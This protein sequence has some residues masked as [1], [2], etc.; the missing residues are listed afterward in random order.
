MSKTM[1][2]T[3]KTYKNSQPVEPAGAPPP[4]RTNSLCRILVVDKNSDLRLLYADALAGPRCRVDVAEDGEAAWEALQADRYNLLITENKLPNLVGNELLRKLRAAGMDLPVVIVAGS[5]PLHEAAPNLSLPCAATLLKPF[6]LDALLD[7]VKN[8]LCA[9]VPMGML[10]FCLP[11]AIHGLEAER[12]RALLLPSPNRAAR[13]IAVTL[14][15]HGKC[16]YSQDDV[17]FAKLERGRVLKQGAIVR[18][19]QDA[20]TDLLL[21]R[22]GTSVRLLAGTEIKLEKMDLAIK[23]GL[24]VVHT[25]LALHTGRLLTVV[26][27]T[28]AGSTLEIRN[29]AGRAAAEASGLSRCIIT[30]DGTHVWAQ[31]SA[32]PIKVKGENGRTIIAAGQH[33][34]RKEGPF[35]PASTNSWVKDLI[36]LDELQA[37]LD[38]FAAEEP[39]P[40]P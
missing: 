8:V 21:R 18:T 10:P 16:D 36:Q 32:I 39:P 37:V 13:P 19:G 29:A 1:Y 23:D 27:S 14:A 4:D 33:F 24:P 25:L 5:L 11:A 28:V 2:R 31:G 22:T 9:A 20:R 30:A 26:H 12:A 35:L 40:K 17:S 7:T 34:A 38:T 6:A 15:V 3:M